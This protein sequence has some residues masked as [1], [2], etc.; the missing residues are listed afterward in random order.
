MQRAALWAWSG[1]LLGAGGAASTRE[2]QALMLRRDFL[3]VSVV[4]LGLE[5]RTPELL[6]CFAQR[7]RVAFEP[8]TLAPGG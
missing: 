6:E 2:D 8:F 5:P 7:G 1:W 4:A 3:G